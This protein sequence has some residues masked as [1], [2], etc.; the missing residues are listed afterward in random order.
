LFAVNQAESSALEIDYDHLCATNATLAFFLTNAPQQI[1]PI[2]DSVAMDV[3]LAGFENYD[4]IHSEVHVRV[5]NLPAVEQLRDLR[6]EI[7]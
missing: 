2:F 5:A 4:K 1:L 7:C 3:V 6:F